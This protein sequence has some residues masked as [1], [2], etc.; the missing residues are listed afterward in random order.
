MRFIVKYTFAEII[1]TVLAFLLYVSRETCS[2]LIFNGGDVAAHDENVRTALHLAVKAGSLETVKILLNPMLPSTLEEKDADQN[3]ALH[4][5]CMHNRLDVLKFLV[6]KGADVTT[7]NKVNMTCLDVAIEW[8][9]SEVAETLV[10][11]KRLVC[12]GPLIVSDDH[13]F[14]LC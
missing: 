13:Q 14:Q 8:G 4:I 6:D 1:T 2:L 12:K 11:H 3:T 10:R 5:A 7:R 9:A